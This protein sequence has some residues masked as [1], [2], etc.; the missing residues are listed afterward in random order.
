MVKVAVVHYSATGNVF[1]L[2]TQV[3]EGAAASGAEVR[4]LRVAET[5]DRKTID[6]NDAWRQH[7]EFATS[8]S[9]P[10][11]AELAD[12]DWADGIAIGSPTRF[13]GPAAQLK[14]FTDTTGGL[15]ANGRLEQ[16]VVTAFTAAST[17]HGGLESTILSMLNIAYHWGSIIMPV[18]YTDPSLRRHG[19]PYGA[20]WVARSGARPDDTALQAAY[21]QGRR[22]AEVCAKLS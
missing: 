6:L 17:S 2:A 11:L 22:L 8:P 14:A 10:R 19:N 21:S 4:L 1:R 12:L 18:G 9:G 16:K 15:W 7:N 20:S 5:A 3:A 13:G